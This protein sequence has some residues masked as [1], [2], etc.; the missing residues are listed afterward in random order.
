[1]TPTKSWK[2]FELRVSKWFGGRRRGADFRG[3][4]GAGKND[5]IVDGWSP[6]CKLLGRPSFQDCLN[7]AK[8]AEAAK[9]NLAD[10]AVAIVKRKGDDDADSLFIMRKNEFLSNFVSV[11]QVKEE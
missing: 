9:E 3:F 6:E 8:Q 1:M 7:A 5:I 10:I 4:S 11:K 2:S